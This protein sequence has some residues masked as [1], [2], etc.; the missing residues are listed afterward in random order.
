LRDRPLRERKQV[1]RKA[2]RWNARVRLD[3]NTSVAKGSRR[4]GGAAARDAKAVVAKRLDSPYVSAR[5]GAWLKIKCSGRQEFAIGGFTDP[6][7]SRFGL[8]ALLVGYYSD[9]GKSFIYAGK[10]G[11]GFTNADADRPAQAAGENGS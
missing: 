10:V 7:R 5:S 11:T 3:L 4:C 1:L 6:Q 8:G 2:L 9:D